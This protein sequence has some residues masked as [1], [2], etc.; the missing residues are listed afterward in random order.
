MRGVQAPIIPVIADLIHETPGTISLGQGVVYYGPPESALE[1]ARQIDNSLSYH[2][3]STVEGISELRTAITKKLSTENDIELNDRRRIVVTAGSNMAFVNAIMAIADPGDEI[4]LISPYYFNHEM[5]VTMLNCKT[6]IVPC[7]ETY[8][9]ELDE[10]QNAITNKTKAIVTVSPNNPSGAVYPEEILRK[11]NALCRDNNIY[12]ISDEA[13]EYFTFDDAKHFSPASI[14]NSSEY[15][16]ALFS[17]SKAYGFAS[18]RIGYMVIP[19]DLYMPIKKVQDTYLICPVRISQ[20]AAIAAMNEGKGFCLSH[21]GQIKTV[22][23]ELYH[24]LQEISDFCITPKTNGAFYFL[25]KLDTKLSGMKVVESLIKNHKIAVIPGETFGLTNGCYLRI[26]YGALDKKT[27]SEGI[28]R[29]IKGLSE[30][31]KK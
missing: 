1:R 13:Y 31:I 19:E 6:V 17:L 21:I 14:Q 11:I 15:T 4:I 27:S 18:W 10:L 26:A 8:Q 5:A 20:E 30:I 7:D 24:A 12:H 25:V 3:Y 22:R 16:I 2:L 9:P 23:N 28:Q 29:L